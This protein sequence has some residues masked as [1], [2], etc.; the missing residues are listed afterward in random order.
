[1]RRWNRKV[2]HLFL[3]LTLLSCNLLHPLSLLPYCWEGHLTS[4]KYCSNNLLGFQNFWHT[5]GDPKLLA[6]ALSALQL[7]KSGTLSLQVSECIPLLSLDTF[8]VP[9]KTIIS[10]R[11][12][13]LLTAFLFV[14]HIRLL[15]TIVCIYK[16]YLLAY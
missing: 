3:S 10:N 14:L 2:C 9:S 4:R 7:P 15:L 13:D 16:L 6:P 11:P 8:L 12:F 5:S 1:M